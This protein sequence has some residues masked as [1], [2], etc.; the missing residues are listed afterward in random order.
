MLKNL[1]SS[2]V[3]GNVGVGRAIQYFTSQGFVVSIP[4]N[5]SQGYDLIVEIEHKLY[6][7]QVKTS[8]VTGGYGESWDI[9]LRTT[10]GTRN[11]KTA[12]NFDSASCDSIF[13][14]VDTGR[15]WLIPTDHVKAKTSITVGHTKWSQYE[16]FDLFDTTNQ[17]TR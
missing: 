7:I 13:V 3:K 14:V 17:P 4:L 15:M 2:K 1:G 11:N 12:K 5:D 9:A 16:V 10:G 6:R 8:T